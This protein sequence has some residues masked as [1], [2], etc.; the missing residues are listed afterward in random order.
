MTGFA[1]SSGG[2]RCGFSVATG[3]ARCGR[4]GMRSA[5][6]SRP[7]RS[8][9][10]VPRHA[11]LSSLRAPTTT[12]GH[13]TL[14][15]TADLH[16]G[17]SAGAGAWAVRRAKGLLC[18]PGEAGLSTKSTSSTSFIG[19]RRR[20]TFF[21][22]TPL[23]KWA[24]GLPV[25]YI[26][27]PRTCQFAVFRRYDRVKASSSDRPTRRLI[28]NLLVERSIVFLLVVVRIFFVEVFMVGHLDSPFCFRSSVGSGPSAHPARRPVNRRNAAGGRQT[29]LYLGCSDLNKQTESS[30]RRAS[31]GRRT[32]PN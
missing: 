6:C 27:R 10:A 30:A 7:G 21:E 14:R 32:L 31:R 24:T 23:G 8:C 28:V 15:L 5:M 2:L 13:S 12:T 26:N 11:R 29:L 25:A 17:A 18:G 16:G 3:A 4:F 20:R 22:V 9:R 19:F 1:G